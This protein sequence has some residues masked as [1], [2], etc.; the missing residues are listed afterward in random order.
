MKVIISIL[1]VLL[2]ST[3]FVF[4]QQ[5]KK[6]K[7]ILDKSSATF[8]TS[9]GV[10]ASFSFTLE[11][12]KAK[13]NE[14]INGSIS[15]QGNKFMMETPDYLAWYNG[16]DQWVYMKASNEVNLTAPSD[17]ETQML[18]PG[19][20]LTIYQ[21]GFNYKYVGEKTVSGKK[22]DEI[23]LIPQQKSE[24]KK[25]VIQIDKI[26]QLPSSIYLQNTNGMNNKIQIVKYQTR[27]LFANSL[28]TFDKS[29]Y[30][31]A[32]LIDLR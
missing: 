12:T 30:P 10:K 28:F 21:K 22:V 8:S 13:T 29:K 17:D 27:Q 26:S 24:W 15:M 3:V 18:N 20:I 16:T 2:L 6:A 5:D 11:N 32:E 9:G 4:A 1:S 25:L 7:E 14:T 31:G 23:E 19:T